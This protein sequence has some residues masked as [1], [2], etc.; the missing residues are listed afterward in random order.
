MAHGS[1]TVWVCLVCGY[2]HRGPEPPDSCPIC[3]S[4]RSDFERSSET[5]KPDR[6]APALWRCLICDHRHTG[7]E[8]PAACS[9]C[10]ARADE[11]ESVEETAKP[12]AT[13]VRPVKAVIVGAGIAGVSAAEALREAS[14]D[15]AITLISKEPELPYYRLNLTRY[16]AGEIDDAALSIHPE[17]WYAEQRIRL[18]RGVEVTAVLPEE[19][20]VE[21]D[22]GSREPFEKAIFACGAHPFIPP[23]PGAAR[24]GV[25]A[26]RTIQDARMLMDVVRPGLECICIGGGILGLETAYGLVKRGARVTILEGY[27]WLLPRQLNRKAGELLGKFVEERGI[28]VRY[29]A[30]TTEIAGEQ[31]VRGVLLEDGALLPAD[32]VVIATGIRPNSSLARKA[33]V[34]V[35]QGIVVGSHLRSSVAGLY[36]AGDVSEHRSIVYGLWEPARYQGAI[37]G[38]NAAGLQ[39]EFG[40]LPRAN[41]LKVLGADL[42]S[43][44][45]VS[46]PDGG[47]DVIDQAVD[48]R[49]YHFLFHDNTL[50]GAILLGDTH[51]AAAAS[52]V[53][54]NRTDVSGLL[55]KRPAAQDVVAFLLESKF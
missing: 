13:A 35:N 8:P 11:F 4:G 42:F 28:A 46:P 32:R 40:G 34:T 25:T 51:G 14:P 49:Y 54:K 36:A 1:E 21:L 41:T 31:H 22:D 24:E 7:S 9:V 37:A 16:L 3:G 19:K 39:A 20:V 47:Y 10:G 26:F 18:L 48:G 5:P 44:G 12:A 52:K 53:I 23:F 6:P 27:D 29:R 55:Q 50:V 17:S 30:K 38:R 45:M 2:V 15:A 43:I 33:G